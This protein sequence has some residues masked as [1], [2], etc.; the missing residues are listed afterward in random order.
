MR[1]VY[2]QFI[3]FFSNLS[4]YELDH[5]AEVFLV[6]FED[7]LADRASGEKLQF[8]HQDVTYALIK[9]MHTLHEELTKAMIQ[10]IQTDYQSAHFNLNPT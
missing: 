9:G 4:P 1:E 5:V 2:L 6:R 8:S 7:M 3:G 10:Q